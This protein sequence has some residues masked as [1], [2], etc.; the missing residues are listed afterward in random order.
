S[1]AEG[2]IVAGNLAHGKDVEHGGVDEKVD[3]DHGKEAGKN[4]ARD[5]VAGILDFI[6]EVDDAVP[7][8][9]CVDGGLNAEKESGDEGRADGDDDGSRGLGKR[10]G[11]GG[12]THVATQGEAGD[13][14]DEE[15]QALEDGSE[16]LHFAAHADA[17]PLQ[18]GED[19][20]RGN[21]GD[22]DAHGAVHDGED[23]RDV[24]ADDDA[25]GAG[26]AAEEEPVIGQPR[27]NVAGGAHN[28]GRDGIAHGNGDTKAD[29]E[30]LQELAAVLAQAGGPRSWI[31]RRSVSRQRQR[32]VSRSSG[33]TRH[34]T[35]A[36]QK[37]KLELEALGMLVD[38]RGWGP[39]RRSGNVA[40]V[41]AKLNG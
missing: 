1:E 40:Q 38:E 36:G 11:F 25:D 15:D 7:A 18:Q 10:G 34:H 3:G 2:E 17:S 28:A 14:H 29:T 22:F 27:G 5:Q 37:S 9:V 6:A 13:D 4:G 21:G 24:L 41:G 33:S 8:V 12:V 26:G 19:N 35:F 30:D 23:V 20:D 32:E 16:V 31:G 39:Q